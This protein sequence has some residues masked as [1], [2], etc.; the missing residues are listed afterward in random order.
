MIVLFLALPPGQRRL[1][2]M[3][4]EVKNTYNGKPCLSFCLALF[5]LLCSLKYYVLS[6]CSPFVSCFAHHN[7][8]TIQNQSPIVLKADDL[9]GARDVIK[10]RLFQSHIVTPIVFFIFTLETTK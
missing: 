8:R 10:I 6:F 5:L 7:M 1:R 2:S 3:E 9:Q 4:H